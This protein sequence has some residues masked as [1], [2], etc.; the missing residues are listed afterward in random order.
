[1]YPSN[2]HVTFGVPTAPYSLG[3]ECNYIERVLC[4]VRL[5]HC[6][7][8][9]IP[10]LCDDSYASSIWTNT[11]LSTRLTH[12]SLSY[13]CVVACWTVA[14]SL[15]DAVI[16]DGHITSSFISLGREEI[17]H[18][19]VQVQNMGW[20]IDVS[21]G[22]YVIHF[23]NRSRLH[24]LILASLFE[25]IHDLYIKWSSPSLISPRK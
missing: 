6:H 20:P 5:L 12:T 9:E 21:A 13:V 22:W 17:P 3:I 16:S 14:D 10:M 15:L 2:C 4:Y 23:P 25:M 24:V 18:S 11:A 1:M 8:M 19:L 7:C